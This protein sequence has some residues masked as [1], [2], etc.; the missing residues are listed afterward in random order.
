MINTED[1]G[2]TPQ[3]IKIGD[4]VFNRERSCLELDGKVT[5]LEP[6]SLAF[7]CYLLEKQGE[8]VSRE[9]LLAEVWNNR[10]VS[11]DSIR[12]VVKKLREAFNDDAKS[13]RYIKTIPMQGYALVAPVSIKNTTAENKKNLSGKQ[14][15]PYLLIGCLFLVILASVFLMF[16]DKQS[17]SLPVKSAPEIELLTNLSG[18]EVAGTYNKKHDILVFSFRNSN[19]A[20]WQLYSRNM[21]TGGV[22]RLTWGEGGCEQA[23]LSPDGSQIT[24][25]YADAKSHK[26]ILADFDPVSGISNPVNLSLTHPNK[27]ALSWSADGSAL[28]FTSSEPGIFPKAIFR[29][30]LKQQSWQQLTFPNITG[31]GD[32]FAKESPDGSKLA[33]FRNVADRNFVM[34]ILDLKGQKLITEKPLSFFPSSLVWQGDAKTLS[35]SSF[36]GDFYH[37]ALDNDA[38]TEQV[39]SHPGLNDVF[40]T[41][42]KRCFYMRR[43]LMDYTDILEIPNPFSQQKVTVTRHIESVK[44]DFNP[45]Y[46]HLGDT[47]YYTS[48]DEQEAQ[49]IRQVFGQ[50]PQILYRYNPRYVMTNLSLN[51]QET[52]VLGKI[53]NRIFVLDIASGTLKFITSAMEIVNHPTWKLDGQAIYFSRIEKNQPGLL[54]YDLSTDKLTRLEQ[55]ILRRV[56]LMDGRVFVVDKKDDLYQLFNGSAKDNSRHFI[57][58]LPFANANFWQIDKQF[59]YFSHWQGNDGYLNRLVLASGEKKTVLLAKNSG[60]LEF[61]LH[62]DGQ[63]LLITQSLLADSNLV[64]VTWPGQ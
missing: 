26:T 25:L 13:P 61:N 28:Y 36:K 9:A 56:E 55:D 5:K 3:G 42:G 52:K 43:H 32:Y 41:C 57:T 30:N 8:V 15:L 11:D 48:K 24:Y 16:E 14:V 1:V 27:E 59:L 50:A 64:K 35:I 62:P 19:S 22:N 21:K 34:F 44:A 54:E 23:Q 45:I 17:T 63:K 38:L 4:A 39:G 51:S 49:L 60:Q 7:L 29:L 40:F 10:V 53:E 31:F 37:Y 20:P 12:K 33:V 2:Q 46:N 58:H 47:L 6:L 18:S